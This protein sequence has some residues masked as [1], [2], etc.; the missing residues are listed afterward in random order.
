MSVGHVAAKV[1]QLQLRQCKHD[2]QGA[3]CKVSLML[4]QCILEHHSVIYSLSKILYM[5]ASAN[6]VN[7]IEEKLHEMNTFL[8]LMRLKF[9]QILKLPYTWAL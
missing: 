7:Q 6:L 8:S 1:L 3:S 4:P 5:A 2:C 9:T